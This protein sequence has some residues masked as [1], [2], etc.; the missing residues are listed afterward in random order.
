ME[1]GNDHPQRTGALV[2]QT[3]G[4]RIGAV[5]QFEDGGIHALFERCATWLLLLMTADTVNTETLA[6]R[7]TS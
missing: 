1:I 5:V 3:L 7:A 2:G 6:S 4:E